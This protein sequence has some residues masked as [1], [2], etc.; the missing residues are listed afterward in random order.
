VSRAVAPGR[1]RRAGHPGH[2][3]GLLLLGALDGKAVFGSTNRG[4]LSGAAWEIDD[5][6]TAYDARSLEASGFEGGKMLARIDLDD[7]ATARTVEQCSRAVSDLAARDLIAMVEP[8]ISARVDGRVRN[9][10][11]TE[12]VIKA[13]AI[14][15][16][17]G[18]TSAYTW[19]KI[20]VVEDM[21]RVVAASTLPTVLL[22]GEVSDDQAGTFDSWR[23]ALTLPNVLGLVAGRSLLY[24]PDD[25]V[26]GAVDS[27]V[28]LFP[29]PVAR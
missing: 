19:L 5:R 15:A 14:A 2:P 26:C 18:R 6:F 13:S 23:A 8:F 25:D 24:P 16:A 27:A 28:S 3:G 29:D 12:A 7:P 20:P 10:L 21:E 9:Q 1:H 4:G 17:L 22:G 11:T